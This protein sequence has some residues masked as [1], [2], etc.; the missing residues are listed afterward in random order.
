MIELTIESP[1]GEK[2][3]P[4]YQTAPT[5]EENYERNEKKKKRNRNRKTGH[6]GVGA[7]RP[8]FVFVF[9]SQTLQ[10]AKMMS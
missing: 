5:Q 1:L 7:S 3:L 9:L 10:K 6:R 8:C 2:T 4:R